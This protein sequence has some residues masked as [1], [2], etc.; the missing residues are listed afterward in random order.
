[1]VPLFDRRFLEIPE[2]AFD[3]AHQQQSRGYQE[4]EPMNR[5]HISGRLS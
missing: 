5:S 1:M 4:A 2:V 3:H